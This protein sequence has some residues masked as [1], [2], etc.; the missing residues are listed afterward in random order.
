MVM[1]LREMTS[2]ERVLFE[3]I[4]PVYGSLFPG[5]SSLIPQDRTRI[6]VTQ[7]FAG[8]LRKLSSAQEIAEYDTKGWPDLN[9]IVMFSRDVQSRFTILLKKSGF[10]SD[11]YQH[12]I[13]HELTHVSDYDF[14]FTKNG[15]M[16]LA[17]E[18]DKDRLLF[19]PFHYWSEFHAKGVGM[20]FFAIAKTLETTGEWPENGAFS[21]SYPDFHTPELTNL[22]ER[23]ESFRS[24]D[25]PE[26]TD[27]FWAFFRGIMEY[28]GRMSVFQ[29]AGTT[30]PPDRAYPSALLSSI[31]GPMVLELYPLLLEMKTAESAVARL[32]S[33]QEIVEGMTG[34]LNLR[35]RMKRFGFE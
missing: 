14:F 3:I 13:P 16:K 33:L 2:E 9:G 1:D 32:A 8:E 15:N 12:T 27:R 7:D 31:F 18:E 11:A 26:T 34:Y 17:S 23:V 10:L 25:T 29:I 20:K 4:W 30:Q 19:W 5:E 28:L 24:R 35:T 22:A 6:V 21:F